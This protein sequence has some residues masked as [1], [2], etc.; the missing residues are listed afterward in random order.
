[1]HDLEGNKKT[2]SPINLSETKI[3]IFVQG[4]K[5]LKILIRNKKTNSTINL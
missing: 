3:F 2:N 1:M 5:T 4:P